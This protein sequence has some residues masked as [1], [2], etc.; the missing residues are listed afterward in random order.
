MCF[1]TILIASTLEHE[2]QEDIYFF[3][4]YTCFINKYVV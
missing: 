3:A 1:K 4:D 2:D